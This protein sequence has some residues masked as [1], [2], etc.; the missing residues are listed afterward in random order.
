MTDN[1]TPI[2]TLLEK[3]EDY[4]KTTIELF[5]LQ[6]IDKSANVL[7]SLISRI[8]VLMVVA[9]FIVIINYDSF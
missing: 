3:I 6:A 4:S 2:A 9:L 8:A 5:K 1:A 7:S